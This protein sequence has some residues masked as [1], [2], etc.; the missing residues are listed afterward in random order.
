[1]TKVEGDHTVNITGAKDN[2]KWTFTRSI[3][4]KEGHALQSQLAMKDD[5][6]FEFYAL[7]L[8]ADFK[9]NCS[10]DDPK[11]CTHNGNTGYWKINA[12]MQDDQLTLRLINDKNTMD[13]VMVERINFTTNEQTLQI[14]SSSGSV[15]WEKSQ[16]MLTV[17]DTD[18]IQ[19]NETQIY[20]FENVV[21]NISSNYTEYYSKESGFP[22]NSDQTIRVAYNTNLDDKAGSS[23][24]QITP[25][26]I[27]ATH[28]RN[29]NNYSVIL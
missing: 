12:S 6:S 2:D 5:N 16:I 3:D 14:E 9:F 13:V 21:Y 7:D 22:I 20:K 1:M 11:N 4:N 25:V 29:T 26:D 18:S 15:L 8:E 17:N 24:A 28:L 19:T 23:D 27:K 10:L